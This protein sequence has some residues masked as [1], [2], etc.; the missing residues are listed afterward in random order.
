[1]EAIVLAGGF[2]TRLQGIVKD[3]PKS[4]A[5]VNKR[6]FLEYLFDY[7]IAQGISRAVL[8][9]GY[10]HEIIVN[11][12]DGHYKSLNIDYAIETE[13][14]GTG[15]GIRNALW[16]IE[17]K[18]AFAMN[19]D[20]IFKIDYQRMLDFHLKKKA[21]ATL[22]L[23]KT[24]DTARFGLVNVD[25][26]RRIKGFTEKSA[27]APP[28]GLINGGVYLIEKL[29]LMEPEFRGRF[30]IEKDCFERYSGHL[31]FY[32]FVSDGYFHDIGVPDD[33]QKAQDD[34]AAFEN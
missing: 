12:F 22:A 1:L 23:F 3:V 15:G 28:Q 27:T 29:F 7:L 20:T 32:G 34:F 16:K 21:D 2:G 4:M 26:T 25:R 14:L 31:R 6:P 13:P 17:G 10:T 30:S 18:Q 8:S 19:G 9:V 11:H 24:K 33:Y 5:L